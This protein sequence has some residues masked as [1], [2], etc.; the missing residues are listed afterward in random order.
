MMRFPGAVHGC[1]ACL[2][3]QWGRAEALGN[4]TKDLSS[5]CA[6]QRSGMLQQPNWEQELVSYPREGGRVPARREPAPSAQLLLELL[7]AESEALPIL[8]TQGAL[9]CREE[10]IHVHRVA[11]QQIFH[12]QGMLP[13][14]KCDH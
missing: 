3:G 10:M 6:P 13:G 5:P 14:L 11:P 1:S 4:E 8:P 9:V 2:E 12:S 7:D